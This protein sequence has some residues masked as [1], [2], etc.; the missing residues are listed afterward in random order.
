M[1]GQNN[2]SQIACAS[3][4]LALKSLAI[5]KGPLDET[6]TRCDYKSMA[7]LLQLSGDC[8][9]RRAILLTAVLV[10]VLQPA[11]Q[12]K[13]GQYKSEQQP[14]EEV[15]LDEDLLE[16]E[17]ELLDF[18]LPAGLG[19]ACYFANAAHHCTTVVF[20]FDDLTEG[21]LRGPTLLRAPPVRSAC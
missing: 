8:N 7:Y 16:G 2:Q 3:N 10:A 12:T 1:Q 15:E 20:H 13:F 9:Y 19:D 21:S 6:Q 18:V 5:A 4:T 14:L 17:E 11:I